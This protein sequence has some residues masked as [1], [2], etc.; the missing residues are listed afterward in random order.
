MRRCLELA[1][2]AVGRTSPNP[3]VGAVI[4]Q[5]NKIIA[6]GYH[7][8][9]GLPHAEVEAIE[10]VGAALRGRQKKGRHTGLPLQEVT[11]YINLEPCCHQGRTPPCTEAIV[12]SGIRN[13]VVGVG[14][15]NPLVGGK[16]IACLRKKGVRVE[17]GIL[18]QECRQ[19]NEVYFKH[20][21][22][23]LPFVILKAGV[24]LDGM[25]ATR[26]G[27]SRWITSP[28]SRLRAHEL[29][30]QV[31]AIA[32]GANTVARDNPQLTTR[33][34]GG[35]GKN[36]LRLVLDSSLYVEPTAKVFG[37]TAG[38]P[39]V[40]VTVE[41][42]SLQRQKLFQKAGV[43]ILFCRSTPGGRIDLHD[44]LHKLGEKGITS[45][46]VEGGPGIH[47]SFIEQ[48]LVDKLLLF[49]SPR[50]LGGGGLPMFSGLE[51]EGLKGLPTLH[52]VSVE[53]VGPDLLVTGY[54]LPNRA[55]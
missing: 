19:Q 13:V 11:L 25:V 42:V 49:Y 21:S 2:Q 34:P 22:T 47:S 27:D 50:F 26:K 16:G 37:K 30:D 39:P 15:P 29:R 6:E 10:N 3:M 35:K 54:L 48:G 5:K 46:L 28:E 1:R 55:D 14:D 24:T 51:N 12:R 18:E 40:V 53:K 17:L 23:G 45:L 32:V 52:S 31:D 9:A 20:I 33:I 4:V 38:P 43:E 7:H 44:F 41:R 36:P 8:K